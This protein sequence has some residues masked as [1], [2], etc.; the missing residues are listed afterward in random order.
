[1]FPAFKQRIGDFTYDAV[2]ATSYAPRKSE[3]LEADK[4]QKPT[5]IL[6]KSLQMEIHRPPQ[7]PQGGHYIDDNFSIYIDTR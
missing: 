3:I 2:E 6:V 5:D 1:M 4:D 7:A